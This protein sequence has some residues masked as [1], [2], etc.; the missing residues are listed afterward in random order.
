MDSTQFINSYLKDLS[1]A[2]K[3][4]DN[5]VKQLVSIRNILLEAKTN[6]NKIFIFGNGGSASIANHISVDLTKNTGLR[7]FN[8][9]EANLITCFANDYGF[10][11]WIEKTIEFYGEEGDILIAISSSGTSKNIINSVSAARDLEF[12]SVITLS[13]FLKDNPLSKLGNENLWLDSS[14]Y[15]FIESVHQVWLLAVVD[16]LIGKR[17]Y[18]A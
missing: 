8:F 4:N 17:E 9:N 18:S 5:I 15:N 12:Q 1:G 7:C 10:D 16:L 3:P 6:N 14:A 2:L 13:G 11:H